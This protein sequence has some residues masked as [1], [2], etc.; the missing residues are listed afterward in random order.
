MENLED[1][2]WFV[3]YKVP[4]KTWP[5]EIIDHTSC[6]RDEIEAY[7]SEGRVL[8]RPYGATVRFWL[9]PGKVMTLQECW[10]VIGLHPNDIPKL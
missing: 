8:A 3:G 2:T 9:T 6:R 4:D 1:K 7:L 10:D 5:Y